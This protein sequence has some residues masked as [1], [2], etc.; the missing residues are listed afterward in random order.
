MMTL[1]KAIIIL[2]LLIPF[3]LISLPITL[4]L[5]L[6]LSKGGERIGLVL[7]KV[8]G[9]RGLA[10]LFSTQS[11]E[12]YTYQDVEN[13]YNNAKTQYPNDKIW[14]EEVSG[15]YRLWRRQSGAYLYIRKR[16]LTGNVP[17]YD[18]GGVAVLACTGSAASEVAYNF[19][20]T[21]MLGTEDTEETF[22][23]GTMKQ[24]S[25]ST[26]AQFFLKYQRCWFHTSIPYNCKSTDVLLQEFVPVDLCLDKTTGNY[27][28]CLQNCKDPVTGAP[29]LEICGNG[30]DDNCN[31]QIDEGCCQ[32]KD[33]DGYYAISSS[34]PQGNDCDDNDP[35]IT[36]LQINS[37]TADKTTTNPSAGETVTLSGSITGGCNNLSWTITI[38]G[39]TF[40]GTGS[41]PSITWDGKDSSGITLPDGT[42]TATLSVSAGTFTQNITSSITIQS[43]TCNKNL[44]T[45]PVSVQT[46]SIKKP[47]L[48]PFTVK[49]TDCNGIPKSGINIQWQI[50]GIPAGAA[51]QTLTAS[52]TTTASD[53][54]TA[55][56]LTLGS[57]PGTYTVTA[58]CSECSSGSP[59]TFTAT[60]VGYTMQYISGDGQTGSVGQSLKEP[61]IT[62]VRDKDNMIVAGAGIQWNITS[63]PA[64]ATGIIL[65]NTMLSTGSDGMASSTLILG[66]KE[67]QYT[68]ESSCEECSSGTPVTFTATAVG[69]RLELKLENEQL[70]PRETTGTPRETKV[71][72]IIKD[73]LGNKVTDKVYTINFSIEVIESKGHEGHGKHPIDKAGKL[74]LPSSCSTTNGECSVTYTASEIAG[75]E[76]INGV[77]SGYDSIMDSKEVTVKVSMLGALAVGDYWR[78]TGSEGTTTVGKCSGKQI[79]HSG[80][81]HMTLATGYRIARMAQDYYEVTNTIIG[82]N[83]ASIIWGGLFD[84]CGDWEK[85]HKYHREGR[86]VDIDHLG[87]NEDLLDKIVEKKYQGKRLEVDQIHYEFP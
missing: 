36:V 6:S 67:G 79:T 7:S 63:T 82:I 29:A 73:T 38:G 10:S 81:H 30:I 47:L 51:G 75:R 54:T 80:N 46:E 66:D 65:T 53:G 64:G 8:E 56:Y 20:R 24:S 71:Y 42:Y 35:T 25:V 37:F 33:G 58:T 87:A 83:D 49:V 70:Y 23:D 5:P 43:I 77:V 86:S 14:I 61:F 19:Y 44:Q 76:K 4:P 48:Q 2:T 15:G 3:S 12:A 62:M 17:T 13:A 69:I 21:D 34:C 9:V 27:V 59:Q 78:L 72:A 32:D 74:S 18:S 55:V 39:N 11:A 22:C 68:V 85:P 26:D 52:N 57:R 1:K 45:I 31:G 60:A 84:V 50:T 16:Y 41:N 40:T 28:P